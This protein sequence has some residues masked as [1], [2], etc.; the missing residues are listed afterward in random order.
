MEKI[1]KGVD[2]IGTGVVF[3][4]HDGNGKFVMAK[5]CQQTRDEQSRWDI[6]GGSIEFGQTI[7]QTLRDEIRQEYCTT[8]QSF[9][10]LGYR[11]VH[12]T[13]ADG[14]PTHWICLDF[15]VLVDP[16]PVSIGE[17]HKFDAIGWFTL[18]DYPT[19]CHSQFPDFLAR[20]GE[21]LGARERSQHRV[22]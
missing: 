11:D 1:R 2:Y 6:G 20:Y 17:P 21:K 18:D 19:Q 4:C 13:L 9:E 14:T 7:D 15:K 5:R 12:R 16:A 22:Q 3:F 10:Y 8:V